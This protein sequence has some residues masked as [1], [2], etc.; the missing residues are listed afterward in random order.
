MD[1]LTLDLFAQAPRVRRILSYGGGTDSFAML[2]RALQLGERPDAVVFV[3][4]GD[5]EHLDPAEWPSTYRH[6]DEH[7][8]PLLAREGIPFHVVDST[9]YPVR[10]ARSLFAWLAARK[11]IPVSGPTRICTRIAK[12][13]RFERWAQDTFPGEQLEVW[14]G[15]EAGEEARAAKDPNAGKPSQWRR[16]R[17][18]LIE[19]GL[20]RCQSE[21][22]IR[23]AGFPVPR[24][25]ACTFCPYA[26]KGDYQTLARELPETFEAIAQLEASKPPTSNGAKLSIKDFR[27]VTRADGSKEYRP[28]FLPQLVAGTY[29]P[30]P[31][32]CPVCGQAKARKD[33]GCSYAA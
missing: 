17:F 15:F 1:T 12:V 11:Q 31:A 32:T 9:T 18:P 27:T 7:L 8:R 14:I 13:E 29:R 26:T 19:W 10:D 28:V 6:I 30:R 22:L 33:T 3:D 25:S 4:V 21:Q 24:K 23:D 5:P 16:N 20:C 2:L